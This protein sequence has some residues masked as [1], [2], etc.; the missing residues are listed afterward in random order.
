[1]RYYGPLICMPPPVLVAVVFMFNMVELPVYLP[2]MNLPCRS[3]DPIWFED[4]LKYLFCI[5]LLILLKL[6]APEVL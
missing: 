2:A 6:I 3:F 4:V 5:P 1:M